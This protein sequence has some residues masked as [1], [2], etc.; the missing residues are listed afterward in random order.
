MAAPKEQSCVRV[1]S[2]WHHSI[3]IVNLFRHVFCSTFSGFSPNQ[4]L[5]MLHN[6]AWQSLSPLRFILLGEFKLNI[7]NFDQTIYLLV[8]FL[9][10]DLYLLLIILPESSYVRSKPIRCEC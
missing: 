2:R 3:I 10:I 5:T 1:I 8:N 6:P 7:S 9:F 4:L